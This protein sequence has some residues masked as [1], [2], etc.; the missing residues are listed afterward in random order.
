M[1]E[2]DA[3][4]V[5]RD[6]KNLKGRALGFVLGIFGEARPGKVAGKDRQGHRSPETELAAGQA[7][8]TASEMSSLNA[9]AQQ[10]QHKP[11]ATQKASHR[12]QAAPSNQKRSP[13][14]ALR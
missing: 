2:L 6:G 7:N 13:A 3:V 5:V 9:E 8:E 14:L 10:K 12:V 11:D 1:T 4:P